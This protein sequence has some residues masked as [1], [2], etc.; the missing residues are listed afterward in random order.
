MTELVTLLNYQG[1]R[2]L[3]MKTSERQASLSG[4]T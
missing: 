4:V 2:D 1:H 3:Y